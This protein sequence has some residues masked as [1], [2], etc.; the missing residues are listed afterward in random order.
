MPWGAYRSLRTQR[1]L[2]GLRRP[3]AQGVHRAADS[4]SAGQGMGTGVKRA[5]SSQGRQHS[6]DG[7]HSPVNTLG[8]AVQACP[9]GF[10]GPRTLRAHAQGRCGAGL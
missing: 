2:H 5:R 4:T 9:G 1:Q 6:C 10:M 7:V 8:K 3:L